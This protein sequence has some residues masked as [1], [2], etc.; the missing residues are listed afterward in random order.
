MN[1]KFYLILM[2]L[3][4]FYSCKNE[5][6]KTSTNT[7]AKLDL[8][9]YPKSELINDFELLTNS[10]KEAHTGIY[11]YNTE[12]QFDSLVGVQKNLLKDSLN[13]LQ[14]YNIVSPIVSYTKED[15][16]DIYLPEDVF[17][18]LEVNGTF[19]PLSVLS[20]NE[21]IHILNNPSEDIEIKGFELKKIN[22][23][24]ITEIYKNLFNT[25]ASD[26]FIKQ[27]KYRWLDNIRLSTMYASTIGQPKEF[28]IEVSDPKT[29]SNT[30]HK[31]QSVN[32]ENLKSISKEV[33]LYSDL[34]PAKFKIL[35]PNTA[36]LTFNT[37]HNVLYE[38]NDIEF[39]KFVSNSF[40]KIDSLKVKN[41]IIDL[42]ENGGGTEG[43][44][45]YL[46]SYLTDKPYNK[47]K[48]VEISSFN[49]SFYQYTDYAKEEDFKEL[50]N[51][52]KKEHSLADDGRI[53]R[54]KDIE[55][56]EPLKPNPFL[57]NI[58]ILT[59]GW[60]YSGGAEFS[61]LMRQ[62]T[63]AIFIGEEVGGGFYGNTS[64]Y[65]LE[66]KLPNTKISVDIPLL[67][68]SL[69]VDKGEIGRGVIPDYPIQPTFE[70]YLNRED[71]ILE[72][73]KKLSAKK[74]LPNSV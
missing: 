3:I 46:F 12:K 22:G 23:K 41:L 54:R 57:G 32:K 42:R 73:A 53:L 61:S 34:E 67:K 15:H 26:G 52:I 9:K 50:E 27:S 30:L 11:W 5:N 25:I 58:Y 44:E 36:I 49:Y 72:F 66:L 20:V 45:D 13:G 21:K 1:K 56:I 68:F 28:E 2:F 48:D 63:N 64:G 51:D 62:H 14:F 70:D 65:G 24:S 10:L 59:S 19:I 60:T 33:G 16:C 74:T 71:A 18:F 4:A 39:K 35:Q 40:K 7:L 38:E 31:I 29:N 6:T 17:E 43:N 55:K 37:F 8:K 47:Y 69:D